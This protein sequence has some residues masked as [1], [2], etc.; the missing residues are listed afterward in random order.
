MSGRKEWDVAQ[1]Q[2][3]PEIGPIEGNN[4]MKPTYHPRESQSTGLHA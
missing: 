4:A 3:R 2:L 1:Q